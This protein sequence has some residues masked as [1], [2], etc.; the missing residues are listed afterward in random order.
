MSGLSQ[1]LVQSV[2]TRLVR[3]AKDIA[4]EPNL[5]LTRYAIERLPYRLSI[6]PFRAWRGAALPLTSERRPSPVSSRAPW[7]CRPRPRRRQAQASS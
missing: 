5:V 3:Y 2:Q 1:R 4:V 7:P 6:S